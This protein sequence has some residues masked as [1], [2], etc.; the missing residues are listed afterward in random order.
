MTAFWAKEGPRQRQ[1]VCRDSGEMQKEYDHASVQ[2]APKTTVTSQRHA[3]VIRQPWSTRDGVIPAYDPVVHN[4][5][6][7]ALGCISRV[8]PSGCGGR[9]GGG[10]GAGRRPGGPNS[11]CR[12]P[13][14][15]E[16]NHEKLIPDSLAQVTVFPMGETRPVGFPRLRIERGP[17]AR[18][19]RAASGV[20]PEEE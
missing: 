17:A 3:C 9:G 20:C 16:G 6:I 10:A 13:A 8:A 4:R 7:A 19:S 1:S 15:V 5:A 2:N 12:R 14:R 11:D 18:G